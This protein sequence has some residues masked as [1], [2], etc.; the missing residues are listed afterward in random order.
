MKPNPSSQ[1]TNEPTPET[2]ITG[3]SPQ[4]RA[5]KAAQLET[6]LRV[7]DGTEEQRSRYPPRSKD[8]DYLEGEEAEERIK[9]LAVFLTPPTTTTTTTLPLR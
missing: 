3:Q 1:E 4:G 2:K 9:G 7:Y 5:K 8:N 6:P